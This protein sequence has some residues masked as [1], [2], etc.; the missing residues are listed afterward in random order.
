MFYILIIGYDMRDQIF[1]LSY[2]QIIIAPLIS[3]PT[4]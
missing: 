1:I 4:I 3:L 2:V